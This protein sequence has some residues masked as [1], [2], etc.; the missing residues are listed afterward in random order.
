MIVI[1][2]INIFKIMFVMMM[3]IFQGCW[4]EGDGCSSPC[5]LSPLGRDQV[6]LILIIIIIIIMFITVIRILLLV[7]IIMMIKR[8]KM[9]KIIT[10]VSIN[11][12]SFQFPH[13]AM[14]ALQTISYEMKLKSYPTFKF[15]EAE[16][17]FY[18]STY[19]ITITFVIKLSSV[20]YL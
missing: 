18:I 1:I 8:L 17:H 12:Q 13:G 5:L 15:Y 9:K 6:S 20:S 11:C 2:I 16:H 7:M 14:I 10:S 4:L 19:I 3:A